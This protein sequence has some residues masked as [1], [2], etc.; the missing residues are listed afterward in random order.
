MSTLQH[1]HNHAA[2]AIM[3]LPKD[4][5]KCVMMQ[6]AELMRRHYEAHPEEILPDVLDDIIEETP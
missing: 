5:R 2:Q 1:I 3:R 4:E 6:Q